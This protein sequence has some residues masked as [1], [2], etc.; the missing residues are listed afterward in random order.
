M[1]LNA[2]KTKEKKLSKYK[3]TAPLFLHFEGQ[4]HIYPSLCLYL[5]AC[6]VEIKFNINLCTLLI[7]YTVILNFNF[8]DTIYPQWRIMPL[9]NLRLFPYFQLRETSINRRRT[10]VTKVCPPC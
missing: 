6:F 9:N 5:Y 2:T 1:T 10:F 4:M 7:K 3:N 8:S